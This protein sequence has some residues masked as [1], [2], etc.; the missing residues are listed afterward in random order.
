MREA[1]FYFEIIPVRDGQ[2]PAGER[3]PTGETHPAGETLPAGE[4]GEIVFTTLTRTGMPLV[5]YRT[6]D[7]GRI[8]KNHCDCSSELI[9][10]DKI[11]RRVDG[12]VPI[13]GADFHI[14]DFDEML[15]SNE[16]ILDYSVEIKD[17]KPVFEIKTI[18]SFMDEIAENSFT[19]K[20]TLPAM[21]KK[22]KINT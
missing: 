10:M 4:W 19:D 2:I 16:N 3:L 8:S 7:Y 12:G 20:K 18:Q 5:R 1:D 6:G 13:G 14:S 15:F 17:G 11:R 9:L 22:R 21:L